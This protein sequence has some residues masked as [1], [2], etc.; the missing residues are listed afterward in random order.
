MRFRTVALILMS[1]A[2][3]YPPPAAQ[4]GGQ[5]QAARRYQSDSRNRLPVLKPGVQG[6][7][8]IRLHGSG[9]ERA[10]AV[11]G[12]PRADELA[13]L[14]SARE[15]RSDVRVVAAR[16]GSACRRPRARGDRC[17]AAPEASCGVAERPAIIMSVVEKCSAST[18]SAPIRTPAR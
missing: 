13:I 16:D 14:A 12:W 1:S 3:A 11:A 15:Q 5:R 2:A 9:V 7:E 18:P 17:R 10:M 6:V 4:T 8:A